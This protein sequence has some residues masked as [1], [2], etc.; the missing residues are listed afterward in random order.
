MTD[1]S[2]KPTKPKYLSVDENNPNFS[3]ELAA[4]YKEHKAHMAT[5]TELA[6]PHWIKGRKIEK[7]RFIPLFIAALVR[8][9]IVS[10]AEADGGLVAT[11]TKFGPAYRIIDASEAK[12]TS[13][14]AQL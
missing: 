2:N 14:K 11:A 12:K 9:G 10:Q 7:E 8:G 4:A 6:K 1:K 5:G 13:G 3:G